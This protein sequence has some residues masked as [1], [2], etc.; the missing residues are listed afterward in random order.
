[1]FQAQ[2][3][4]GDTKSNK[5]ESLS[6][7]SSPQI[8][9]SPEAQFVQSQKCLQSKSHELLPK[10]QISKQIKKNLYYITV[11]RYQDLKKKKKRHSD[12]TLQINIQVNH[13]N[14]YQALGQKD[15][16]QS[17]NDYTLQ[18][19]VILRKERGKKNYIEALIITFTVTPTSTNMG[20]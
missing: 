18:R 16:Q 20:M 3:S 5:T 11:I 7:K 19:K 14:H 8:G 10:M 1:M 9:F 12:A 17:P 4:A 15:L 13:V 6:F 2:V